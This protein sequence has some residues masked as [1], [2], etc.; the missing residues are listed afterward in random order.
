MGDDK[1]GGS[2]VARRSRARG[3][4]LVVPRAEAAHERAYHGVLVV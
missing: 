1:E 2:R 4:A 3:L